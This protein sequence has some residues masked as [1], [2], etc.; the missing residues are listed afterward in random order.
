MTGMK[1]IA[2][3]KIATP[4]VVA[5]AAVIPEVVQVD[6]PP[7]GLTHLLFRDLDYE[8]DRAGVWRCVEP[9]GYACDC[10]AVLAIDFTTTPSPPPEAP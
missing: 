2:Q 9:G 3:L 10:G 5:V 1:N 4:A 6:C 8:A 7:C